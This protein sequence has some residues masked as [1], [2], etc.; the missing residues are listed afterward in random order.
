MNIREGVRAWLPVIVA[1]GALVAGGLVA[2]PL[3]GWDTVQLQSAIVPEQPVGEPYA[4][5][6][7]STAIDDVYLTDVHPNGYDEPEPGDSYLVVIATMENLRDEPQIPLGSGR[8]YAFTVPGVLD[9]GELIPSGDY[10]VRLVRDDSTGPVLNPGV[11]DTVMFIFRVSSD[12]FTDGEEVRIGLT[13]ATPESADLYDGIRWRR[14][15]VAVEVPIV[16]RD[17]R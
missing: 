1:G 10:N 7:V 11:P 3:G 16:I 17:E 2:I 14:P 5:H 4:G 8:F 13:D 6:R 12:L 15:H 9:L